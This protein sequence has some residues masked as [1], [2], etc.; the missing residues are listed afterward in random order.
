MALLQRLSPGSRRS[1]SR[2]Y[3]SGNR[4]RPWRYCSKVKADYKKLVVAQDLQRLGEVLRRPVARQAPPQAVAR[5]EVA[6]VYRRPQSQPSN[7]PSW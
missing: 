2:Q 1:A 7:L 3:A 6:P 4:V 5:S